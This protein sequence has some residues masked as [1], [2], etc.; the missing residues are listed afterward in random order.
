MDDVKKEEL[1]KKYQNILDKFNMTTRKQ[2][3]TEIEKQTYEGTFW[4]DTKK[5]SSIMKKIDQMQQ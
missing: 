1:Q 5:A 3:L 4:Q 2:E